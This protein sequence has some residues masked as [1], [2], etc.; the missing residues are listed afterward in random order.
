MCADTAVRFPLTA[1][2]CNGITRRASSSCAHLA[3]LLLQHEQCRAQMLMM[4]K[5]MELSGKQAMMQIN[6]T[7]TGNAAAQARCA[8]TSHHRTGSACCT[9]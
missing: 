3:L 2:P 9:A 4:K 8:A 5:M 1:N 7:D 6:T